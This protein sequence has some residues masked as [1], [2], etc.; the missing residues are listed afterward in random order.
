MGKNKIS[1]EQ[2]EVMNIIQKGIKE[3][4]CGNCDKM[5]DENYIG[6]DTCKFKSMGCERSVRLYHKEQYD[7]I[8]I[9]YCTNFERQ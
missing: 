7:S 4:D 8:P 3:H 2:W 9:S 6:C 5:L 1:E